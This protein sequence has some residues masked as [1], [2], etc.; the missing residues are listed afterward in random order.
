M[1]SI[2]L[3]TI[4]PLTKDEQGKLKGGFAVYAT[5]LQSVEKSSVSVTVRG[6]C[7]CS[8]NA[9]QDQIAHQIR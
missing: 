4:E 7:G 3:K 8:C 9:T 1:K 5:N 2:F 6:N